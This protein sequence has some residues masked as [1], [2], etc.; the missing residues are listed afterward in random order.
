MAIRGIK[1]TMTITDLGG[2][3]PFKIEPGIRR[4]SAT[5]QV[6]PEVLEGINRK[7]DE[8]AARAFTGTFTFESSFTEALGSR[9]HCP[10]ALLGTDGRCTACGLPAAGARAAKTV[11][12][13]VLRQ[14]T[15]GGR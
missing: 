13:V 14:L 7:I 15:E 10:V 11:K 8:L 3:S 4:R 5:G 9:C 1:G 6:D 2:S 12:P